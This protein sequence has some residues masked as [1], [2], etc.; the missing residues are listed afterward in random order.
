MNSNQLL[1]EVSP[2][3]REQRD[4]EAARG[5]GGGG[6]GHLRRPW[7]GGRR[8]DDP[9][10]EGDDFPQ[11][12]LRGGGRGKGEGAEVLRGPRRGGADAAGGGESVE[13]AGGARGGH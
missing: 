8:G 6:R 4:P 11:G 9:A 3:R 13:R 7:V 12:V 2:F 10:A 5:G 1:T